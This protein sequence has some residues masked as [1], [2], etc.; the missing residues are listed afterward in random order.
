M[1]KEKE[2]L[3]E[4]Q[5][6]WQE[7]EQ[8]VEK[9]IDKKGKPVDEEIKQTIVSLKAND[10]LPIGSCEGHLDRGEDYPWVDIQSPLVEKLFRDPHYLELREKHRK[11]VDGG[12]QMAEEEKE[13]F[14]RLHSMI[15]EETEKNYQRVLDILNEFYSAGLP[16]SPEE[17][18]RLSIKKGPYDC[19][20]QPEGVDSPKKKKDEESQPPAPLELSAKNLEIYKKEMGR[21][22]EFL[23]NKFFS[24]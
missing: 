24:Y 2:Y 20:I 21:F 15:I 22:T 9:I 7:I 3:S 13:E 6:K 16:E 5:K 23:K 17:L 1:E 10:F 14:S 11:I 18:R 12:R 4:K 19:R 8:E